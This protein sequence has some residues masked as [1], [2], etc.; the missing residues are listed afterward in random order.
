[1]RALAP[2]RP[3]P[4]R[5]PPD[6]GWGRLEPVGGLRWVD[7]LDDGAPEGIR[8][9]HALLDA[10]LMEAWQDQRG[11]VRLRLTGRRPGIGRP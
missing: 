1:M 10:G 8:I 4:A 11:H 2:R 5:N 9:L 6:A 7:L 3:R